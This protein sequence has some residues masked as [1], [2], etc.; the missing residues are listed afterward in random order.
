MIFSTAFADSPFEQF[1]CG[2]REIADTVRRDTIGVLTITA[3]FSW[4]PEYHVEDLQLQTFATASASFQPSTVMSL[5]NK[6]TS[7]SS[8][9]YAGKG[10]FRFPVVAESGDFREIVIDPVS[11]LR[12]WIRP[13]DLSAA[14]YPVCSA[15]F[16]NLHDV[17]VDIFFFT[18]SQRK[19]I[20][21]QPVKDSSYSIIDAR[22]YPSLTAAETKNGFVRLILTKG[23]GK[24]GWK[25]I[26]WA[27]VRDNDG[28]LSIWIVDSD[29]C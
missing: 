23:S 19:K 8:Y 16:N 1:N 18:D 2:Y 3:S 9:G 4:E 21:E 12:V 11:N 28:L 20:Y 13:A 6:T 5:L 17:K 26:G 24:T 10:S 14:G 25:E 15:D 27:R 7:I 29:E 22:K